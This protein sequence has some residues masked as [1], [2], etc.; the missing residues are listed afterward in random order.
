MSL[1]Q[2]IVNVHVLYML[3]VKL[4]HRYFAYKATH[5]CNCGGLRPTKAGEVSCTPAIIAKGPLIKV[6]SARYTRERISVQHSIRYNWKIKPTY[7]KPILK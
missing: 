3:Y 7:T 1:V 4:G 2:Y 6:L 5:G